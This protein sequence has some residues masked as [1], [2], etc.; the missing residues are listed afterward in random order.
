MKLKNYN[1]KYY[2]TL[3]QGIMDFQGLLDNGYMLYTFSKQSY[4]NLSDGT[5][6]DLKTKSIIPLLQLE[7][8]IKNV[9]DKQLRM[10]AK[11]KNKHNRLHYV[12]Y[13]RK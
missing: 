7:P 4:I 3:Y 11:R 5:C 13:K 12:S 10:I 2:Q 6:L 8:D 9:R 1:S